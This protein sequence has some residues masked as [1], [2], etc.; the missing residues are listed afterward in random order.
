MTV[1]TAIRIEKNGVVLELTRAEAEQAYQKIGEALGKAQAAYPDPLPGIPYQPV[2]RPP[3]RPNPYTPGPKINP[4]THRYGILH[5]PQRRYAKKLE[6]R[7]S[8]PGEGIEV[9]CISRPEDS[10]IAEKP[11]F[12]SRFF[13]PNSPLYGGPVPTQEQICEEAIAP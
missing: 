7:D 12:I 13:D 11:I 10:A 8:V 5:D 1:D 2:T 4:N 3:Y 6:V 9:T